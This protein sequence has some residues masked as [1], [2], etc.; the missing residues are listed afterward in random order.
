MARKKS[1]RK[2]GTRFTVSKK[3]GGKICMVQTARGPRFTGDRSKTGSCK[4][5]RRA[6][7]SSTSSSKSCPSG[8]QLVKFK[9]KKTGKNVRFC[10]EKK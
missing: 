5:T 8:K 9:S 2:V 4:R 3:G 6:A 10:A 7:S 1:R